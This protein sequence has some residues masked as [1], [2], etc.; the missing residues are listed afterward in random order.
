[1]S[2][3]LFLS[4]RDSSS[5]STYNPYWSIQ[6]PRLNTIEA[7]VISLQNIEFPNTVYAIN[8]YYDTFYILETSTFL[9][10][11][12]LEHKNYTGSELAIE[13]AAK[14]TAASAASGAGWTYTAAYDAQTKKFTFSSANPAELWAWVESGSTMFGELGV[15][16]FDGAN[17]QV[18]TSDYPI[19]I[20]GSQYVDIVSNFSTHNW[21]ASTTANVLARVP[22]PVAFGQVVYYESSTE[23]RIFTSATEIT[24]V[25][26]QLRD[27]RGNPWKLPPTQ[28]L[29]LTLKVDL[30]EKDGFEG[31]ISAT[32][33]F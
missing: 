19:N 9:L 3:L 15:H 5:D 23:D 30:I 10:G 31:D 13:L 21:S 6:I 29:S 17:T 1:M 25:S 22:L 33:L 11:I 7:F 16:T 18:K 12:V 26:L 24:E 20:A 2:T 27:D 8:E 32:G 4:S 28:H 14:L